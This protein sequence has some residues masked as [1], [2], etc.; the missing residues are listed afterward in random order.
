[1]NPFLITGYVSPELFCDRKEETERL[2]NS[3]TNNRNVTLFSRRR[4]GKTA[5]IKHTF[6]NLKKNKSLSFFYVNIY[7][8]NNIQEFTEKLGNA[9][10]G[11]FNTE[12]KK[13]SDILQTLFGNLRSTISY[14]QLTGNPLISFD[15]TSSKQVESTI[16]NIFSY[17]GSQDS[18]IIIAFDEFQQINNYP[19]KNVEALLRTYIQ[20]FPNI[21]CIF[22]GSQN[23]LITSMFKDRARPFYQSSELFHLEK[24][25][26]HDYQ[27]FIESIFSK[28]RRKAEREAIE[29]LLNICETHTY[30]VQYFCNRLFS[31]EE[32][33]I[34]N[35][36]VVDTLLQIINENESTYLNYR[37]LLTQNQWTLL[38]AIGKDNGIK[39]ITSNSFIKKHGLNSPSSVKTALDVLLNKEIVYY[40]DK[41]YE[42]DDIF[43]K[44][45][46]QRN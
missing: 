17:L 3:I 14:D 4:I 38:K 6:Y 16:E 21:T 32:K 1:M 41:T 36:L 7:G 8:T 42:V 9:V 45:W 46:L 43:F 23:N 22:S 44:I 33:N 5:L 40:S 11:K 30:Y 39:Q 25:P 15:W 18:G 24:I 13:F 34:T 27:K 12:L 35:Q 20:N 10:L 19:Q 2:V 26:V 37:N 31:S 29:Y 28:R